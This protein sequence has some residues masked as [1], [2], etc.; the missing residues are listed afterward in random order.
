[1]DKILYEWRVINSD[2]DLPKID[3]KYTVRYKTGEVSEQEFKSNHDG[4]ISFWQR[5][6][7][8]W[9]KPLSPAKY[10]K[11]QAYELATQR[12]IMTNPNGT[13]QDVIYKAMDIY[14][15]QFQSLSPA[16]NVEDENYSKGYKKGFEKGREFEKLHLK[17]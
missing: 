14:A 9:L 8:E 10:T 4:V 7:V 1:M 15:A 2:D 11:E 5:N 6:I 13:R 12:E 16:L 17:T 3:G